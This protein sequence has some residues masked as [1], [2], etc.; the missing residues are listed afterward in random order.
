MTLQRGRATAA[1]KQELPENTPR[2]RLKPKAPNTSGYVDGAWWP[3]GDDLRAELPDL[4][5][6]LSVRLGPIDQVIYNIAEWGKAPKKLTTG[7]HVVRL[8][9]YHRQPVNTIELLGAGGKK[10][11]LLVIPPATD[12]NRAHDAMMAAAKR[13]DATTT[14]GLLPSGAHT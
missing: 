14:D 5:A 2:L 3:H 10:I 1:W 7:R 4:L 9:G 6:V 12:S 13:G 11:V 8:A